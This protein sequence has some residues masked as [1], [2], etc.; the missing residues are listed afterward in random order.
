MALL[1]WYLLIDIN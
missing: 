1:Y